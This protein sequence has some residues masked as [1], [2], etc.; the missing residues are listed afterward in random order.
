MAV[1]TPT[2]PPGEA[3]QPFSFQEA[4]AAHWEE[5]ETIDYGALPGEPDTPARRNPARMWTLLAI[6]FARLIVNR[7]MVESDSRSSMFK[8]TPVRRPKR[9]CA[10]IE[11]YIIDVLISPVF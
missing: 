1:V 9:A 11:N 6:I 2:P 8:M 7:G 3:R 4:P 5:E 10:G